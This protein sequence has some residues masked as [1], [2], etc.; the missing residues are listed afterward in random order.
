M[1]WSTFLQ[2]LITQLIPVVL[3][4]LLH[5]WGLNGR[6]GKAPPPTPGGGA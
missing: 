5:R 4:A 3:G 1:S 6:N 2:N